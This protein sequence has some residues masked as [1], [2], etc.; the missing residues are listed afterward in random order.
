M[1]LAATRLMWYSD[2][3]RDWEITND[4]LAH[5]VTDVSQCALS[6]IVVHV[7]KMQNPQHIA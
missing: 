1:V 4:T 3:F 5:N 2:H 6:S 7:V